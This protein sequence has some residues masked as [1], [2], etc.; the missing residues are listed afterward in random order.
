MAAAAERRRALREADPAG[1][2][3]AQKT[4]LAAQRELGIENLL[5]LAASE[6]RAVYRALSSNLPAEAL[7][8]AEVAVSL[9]PDWPE[10]RLSRARALLASST[11]GVGAAAAAVADALAA[12][13]RDP[14]TVRAFEGDLLAALL[15]ALL[16]AGFLT[17][18]L[19]A[20]RTL[21]L[22]LHD[23]HHLPLLRG[24]ADVQAAFLA[25]VLLSMP[26]A[27]GLGPLAVATTWLLFAWLY[28][29]L[30]E[31]L[32][33]TAVLLLLFS[34]PW[35]AERAAAITVWTGTLADHVQQIEHGALS[36]EEAAAD[37]KA[38][39]QGAPPSCSRR[40]AA[41]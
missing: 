33:A 36:D 22:V 1:A 19:P 28:L 7:A 4:L 10:A 15:A 27:L 13:L 9:A 3:A 21:R 8:R 41:T 26:L 6:V 5:P 20:A 39:A 25:L 18:I 37:V 12:A 14:Q 17:L 31:R 40:S 35:A 2:D 38:L 34:L 16:L 23:F 32:V 29:S 24:T 11:G 30:R